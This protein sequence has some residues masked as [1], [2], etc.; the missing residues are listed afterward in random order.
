MNK[1]D[2]SFQQW[3]V[4]PLVLED[5]S[6]E[7]GTITDSFLSLLPGRDQSQVSSVVSAI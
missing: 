4:N 1:E 5:F 7:G 3:E 6:S 2:T